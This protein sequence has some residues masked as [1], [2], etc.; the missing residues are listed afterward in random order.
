MKW[1]RTRP[2]PSGN[3]SLACARAGLTSKVWQQGL[4]TFASAA[5]RGQQQG[6]AKGARGTLAAVERH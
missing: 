1:Q 2:A 3:S 6:G 4:A 5:H